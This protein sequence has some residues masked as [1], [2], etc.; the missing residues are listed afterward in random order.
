MDLDLGHAPAGG[1][2]AVQAE[3]AQGLVVGGHL[4][5][6]LEDVDLHLGLVVGGGGEDLALLGG[7]GGVALDELGVHAA[8]GLNAQGQGGDVQQQQALHVAH[9]HAALE[10]GAHG[11]ALVGVDA[12]EALLAGELLH[13]GIRLEP[14][15]M[16]TLAMSLPDRPASL[17]A[18][19]TGPSVAATRWAV[20]SL[21]LARVRVRSRCLGP[22]ASAVI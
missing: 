15:T 16:R 14:P 18:W 3:A 11:H 22:V 8:H 12:L 20:S 21:N 9:Q 17:M 19:R 13:Q 7:D 10:G 6:A 4:P 2:D 5:L 1:G